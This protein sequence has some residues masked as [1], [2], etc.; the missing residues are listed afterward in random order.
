MSLPF[1]HNFKYLRMNNITTMVR[2]ATMFRRKTIL[3]VKIKP[4]KL[5]QQLII[6]LAIYKKEF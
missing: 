1:L 2:T 4:I 5:K 3:K 6:F